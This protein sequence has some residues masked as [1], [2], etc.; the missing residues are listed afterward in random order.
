MFVV[1]LLLFESLL[2]GVLAIAQSD[3][4][5]TIVIRITGLSS[6]QAPVRVAVFNSEEGWLDDATAV[7]KTVLD[8]EGREREW[9]IRN[10]RYGEYAAAV[11]QD[12]NRDGKLN[13]NFVG[14]PK[15]PYGFS[16]DA[17][18]AFGPARWKDAKFVVTTATKELQIKLK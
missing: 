17:R 14:I 10:V 15:E 4:T 11:F 6:E 9:R 3:S 2:F 8:G 16:R 7:Y 13:R 1:I 12:E 18:G 5:S